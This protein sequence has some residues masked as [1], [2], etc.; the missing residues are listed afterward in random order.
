MTWIDTTMKK[1][2]ILTAII[3]GSFTGSYLGQRW[4]Q[5]A[6]VAQAKDTGP[7]TYSRVL[8]LAPSITEVLFALPCDA[9]V[10]GVTRYCKFPPAALKKPHVGSYLSPNYE[11]I[12]SLQPDLV[13]TLPEHAAEEEALD[14][15]GIRWERVDHRTVDGILAS[16]RTTGHWTQVPERGEALAAELKQ[17][18]ARVQTLTQGRPRP[19]ALVSMGRKMGTGSLKDAYVAGPGSFYDSLLRLAGGENAYRDAPVAYP[20]VTGEGILR[21]DPEVI[22]D[23]AA[24]TKKKGKEEA[25]VLAEW[26][27]LPNMRAVKDNRVHV[28]GEDYVSIPGPRFI[29]LLEAM[30]RA[31]HPEVTWP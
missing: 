19:R 14:K 6:P 28:F 22:I 21:L 17:R 2:L 31:L 1:H 26:Q 16:I 25:Q 13:L 10:V 12:V 7:V 3:I 15:L 8:S 20:T 24:N 4:L 18:I 11:A 23:M 29:L 27:V 9:R 30:A 5:S